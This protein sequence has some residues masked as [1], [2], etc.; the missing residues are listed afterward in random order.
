MSEGTSNR[1]SFVTKTEQ[2]PLELRP[3]LETA[4]EIAGAKCYVSEAWVKVRGTFFFPD[5]LFLFWGEDAWNKDVVFF[6]W[7]DKKGA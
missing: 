5:V 3:R 4:L 2:L 1:P 7:L 6:F